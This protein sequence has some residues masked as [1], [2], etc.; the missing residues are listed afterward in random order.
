MESG[1]VEYPHDTPPHLFMPSPT[2]KYSSEAG[3]EQYRMIDVL[4][5]DGTFKFGRPVADIESVARFAQIPPERVTVLE[6]GRGA[7]I[8]MGSASDLARF[9]DRLYRASFSI[10]LL[11]GEES[12]N[13]I[14]EVIGGA[15][16]FCA[17]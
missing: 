13:F 10:R 15:N 7:T 5:Q 6:S 8:Q 11:P 2:F 1:G 14:A 4:Y 12:Y 17:T 16:N 3:G 9:L